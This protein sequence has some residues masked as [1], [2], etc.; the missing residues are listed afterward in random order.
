MKLLHCETGFNKIEATL[1]FLNV[2][3]EDALDFVKSDARRSAAGALGTPARG[4]SGR[5]CGAVC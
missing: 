2:E 4:L 5:G 1:D 3:Y